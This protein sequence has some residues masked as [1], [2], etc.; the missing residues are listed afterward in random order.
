MNNK[1]GLFI[2]ILVTATFCETALHG[3]FG[4]GLRHYKQ[5]AEDRFNQ[6]DKI[7]AIEELEKEVEFSLMRSRDLYN[8]AEDQAKSLPQSSPLLQLRG[9]VWRKLESTEKALKEEATQWLAIELM[10]N[11]LFGH[12]NDFTHDFGRKFEDRNMPAFY[13][14]LSRARTRGAV[15][16]ALHTSCER[17]CDNPKTEVPYLLDKFTTQLKQDHAPRAWKEGLEKTIELFRQGKSLESV[18]KELKI[19]PQYRLERAPSRMKSPV[20][21]W[22]QLAWERPISKSEK[23]YFQQVEKLE[24]PTIPSPNNAFVTPH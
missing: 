10:K 23:P 2:I 5:D 6:I 14:Q 24:C 20:P 7:D 16:H 18:A 13:K 21:L 1:Y 8:K 3:L 17:Y 9:E 4:I 11:E 22:A 12:G 19:F 15:D